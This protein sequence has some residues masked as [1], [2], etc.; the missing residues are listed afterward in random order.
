MFHSQ[1]LIQYAEPL[2][3]TADK[4]VTSHV[5]HGIGSIRI[6]KPRGNFNQHVTAF[7][8]KI[9]GYHKTG[10]AVSVFSAFESPALDV[11]ARSQVRTLLTVAC[12]GVSHQIINKKNILHPARIFRRILDATHKELD[13]IVASLDYVARIA[14]VFHVNGVIVLPAA[15]AKLMGNS[16]VIHFPHMAILYGVVLASAPYL[17]GVAIPHWRAASEQVLR[18]NRS[19]NP[20][21]SAVRNL[22]V[23]H[24]SGANTV[25]TDIHH[26]YVVDCNIIIAS[27]L[28]PMTPDTELDG[29]KARPRIL[30]RLEI[31]ISTPFC[32]RFEF[33]CCGIIMP[34]MEVSDKIGISIVERSSAILLIERAVLV[35]DR[36]DFDCMCA[37]TIENNSADI[38]R[39]DLDA[40]NVFCIGLLPLR[41]IG[42]VKWGSRNARFRAYAIG[43]VGDSRTGCYATSKDTSA[44]KENKRSAR[45]FLAV[46]P[47]NRTPCSARSKA[48]CRVI[49]VIRK[50][51]PWR[52]LRNCTIRCIGDFFDTMCKK[53][54]EPC[55]CCIVHRNKAPLFA[56]RKLNNRRLC[57]IANGNRRYQCHS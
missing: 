35:I 48:V 12:C 11:C 14:H 20:R 51:S 53:C 33:R 29:F 17:H 42:A 38:A 41:R 22:E 24:S 23:L 46:E 6:E 34:E 9:V 32:M 31:Q 28:K 39:P 43:R 18:L 13:R 5:R 50:I 56:A 37:T 8:K 16:G 45:Q 3:E 47:L 27:N 44:L 10:S 2:P 36:E 26:I 25:R 52:V 30:F 15:H 40:P 55:I 57:H 1:T 49:A 21:K 54:V 7:V 19:A 4:Y